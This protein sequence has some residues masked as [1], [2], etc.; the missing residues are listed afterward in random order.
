MKNQSALNWLVPLVAMLALVAAGAGLF[1]QSGGSSYTF[2]TLYG[3]TVEI[4]GQGLYAHDTIFSAGASQG[5]DLVA[6]FMAL[7][8]LVI[9]F[10]LYRRGSLRAGFLVASVLAYYL[11][12][13]ASLGL[14]VA[15]NNL[16]LVYLVLFSASFFA[17][18]LAL[19]AID[20]PSL[21][22]RFSS[23]LPLRGMAIFM[24]IVGVGVAFIWLS[25]VIGA[26]T[27]NG[28]PEALGAHI[29]LLTYTLDVGIIAPSCLLAGF[30]ILRRASLGYLLTGLLTILLALIGAMVIGQTVMQLN[31]GIQLSIGQVIGKVATWIILGGIAVWLSIVFLRNLSD[32]GL[33]QTVHPSELRAKAESSR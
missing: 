2:N 6:L 17:F 14:V 29:S 8:L 12:Y 9:S 18:L 24:F 20:L 7:P 13:S 16:Y 28:V 31:I 30:L 15:Y 25:D 23:H 10:S 22:A 32:T 1:W 4:Y 26:L 5:G 27:T 33:P 21:P 19:L 3:E 11:Y